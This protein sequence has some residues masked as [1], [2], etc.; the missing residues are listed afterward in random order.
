[1]RGGVDGHGRERMGR[2]GSRGERHGP[3][4]TDRTQ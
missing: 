4:D 3:E 1:M 2:A